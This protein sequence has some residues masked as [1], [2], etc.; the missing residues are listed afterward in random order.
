MLGI[1]V[2][3]SKCTGCR[4]CELACVAAHAGDRDTAAWLL[5]GIGATRIRITAAGPGGG[6]ETPRYRVAVCRHCESP[7]CVDGCVSEAFCLDAKAGLVDVRTSRCVGCWTCVMECPFGAVEL[8]RH[9]PGA[10]PGGPSAFKCDGCR[11]L[12]TPACVRVCLTG[13]LGGGGR[14]GGLAAGRRR[15]RMALREGVE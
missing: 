15:G 10:L 6:P 12:G 2:D 8:A 1:R 5:E 14:A 4:L 9:E 7:V 13:A 3:E 11:E